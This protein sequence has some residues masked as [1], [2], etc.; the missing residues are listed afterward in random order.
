MIDPADIDAAGFFVLFGKDFSASRTRGLLQSVKA[1][2]V[3]AHG[4]ATVEMTSDR[5]EHSKQQPRAVVVLVISSE[6]EKSLPT[7]NNKALY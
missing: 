2:K 7:Q 5:K 3:T 1:I 6:V 4:C